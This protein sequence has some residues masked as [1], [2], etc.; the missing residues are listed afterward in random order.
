LEFFA[1]GRHNQWGF[2]P[3]LLFLTVA[4][5][6]HAG[7]ITA[8][9]ADNYAEAT[10]RLTLQGNKIAVLDYFR[11]GDYTSL[12][13]CAPTPVSLSRAQS[14]TVVPPHELGSELNRP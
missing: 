1:S 8:N 2:W 12:D 4:K 14:N 9:G 5:F 10:L 7:N 3:L 6:R 13:R 11:P